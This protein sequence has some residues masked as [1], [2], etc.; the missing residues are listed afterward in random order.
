MPANK[1]FSY[2]IEDNDGKLVITIEGLYAKGAINHLRSE[3]EAGRGWS[4]LSRM[5]PI[6]SLDLL[7]QQA[8]RAAFE[9][10][11]AGQPGGCAPGAATPLDLDVIFN[12]GF[13]ENYDDFAKNLDRYAGSLVQLKAEFEANQ[14]AR[15][16]QPP[17]KDAAAAAFDKKLA[18]K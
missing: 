17:A 16:A 7:S 6:G 18:T 10:E 13:A 15:L 1:L 3:L 11:L 12:Q 9:D 2:S 4:A 14:A 8:A 5:T